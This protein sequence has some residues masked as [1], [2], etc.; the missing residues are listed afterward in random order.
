MLR[1]LYNWTMAKATHPLAE[2]WLALFAAMEASF[3]PVPPHPLL[4]AM[5]LAEPKKAL[6]FSTVATAGSVIG[7]LLGY[8]IGYYLFASVGKQLLEF[9]HLAESFPHAAC[10][11]RDNALKFIILKGILPIPFKVITISA[12]FIKMSLATFIFASIISRS[13]SFMI[14]GGLFQFYGASIKRVIDKYLGLVTIGFVVF[15][16]AGF[17]FIGLFTGGGTDAESIRCAKATLANF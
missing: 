8:A 11:L 7:G 15:V 16:I 1:S 6:R 9:L 14:V 3:F 13:I 10:Y 17:F 12:G 5:C 2:V 4:G